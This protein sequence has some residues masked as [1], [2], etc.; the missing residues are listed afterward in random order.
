[1]G[2]FEVLW[3][4]ILEKYNRMQRLISMLY[5]RLHEYVET[6]LTLSGWIKKTVHFQRKTIYYLL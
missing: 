6:R 5:L 4:F 1:M 2:L 3:N